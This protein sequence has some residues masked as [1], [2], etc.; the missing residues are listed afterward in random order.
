[1]TLPLDTPVAE[2]PFDA[3]KRVRILNCLHNEEIPTLRD[4]LRHDEADLIRRPNFG[5][6]SLSHLRE[7]IE[8][9][10][11]HLGDTPPRNQYAVCATHGASWGPF[12]T[13]EAAVEWA[14]RTRGKDSGWWV[15]VLVAT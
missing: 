8:R 5:R 2:L 15:I 10:G 6:K 7:V 3:D 1:M 4:L 14:R 13:S 12:S 11:F 9:L